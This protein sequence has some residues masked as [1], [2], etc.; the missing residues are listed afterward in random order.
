MWQVWSLA[1]VRNEHYIVTGCGDAEL[2][3]W[4]ISHRDSDAENKTSVDQL[5]AE[6]QAAALEDSDDQTVRLH[7]KLK[8]CS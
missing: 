3:V 4:K 2:R 5:A 6:L 8:S 7:F 1:L